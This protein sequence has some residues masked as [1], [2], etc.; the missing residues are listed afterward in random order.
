MFKTK[1]LIFIVSLFFLSTMA[2][3]ASAPKGAENINVNGGSKGNVPFPH[4]MHQ[5][6]LQDCQICHDTFPQ[7]MGVIKKL[8]ESGDLKKKQVMN[9]VCLDC[10]KK[11]K[12]AGKDYGPI[13]CSGC[14]KR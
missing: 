13:S 5:D 14:H 8:K 12:K 9:A 11:N 7:E 4:K 1:V 6:V 10:H 2:V 3:I